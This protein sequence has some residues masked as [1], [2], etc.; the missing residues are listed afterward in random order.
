MK[1]R[2][3]ITAQGIA[4]AYLERDQCQCRVWVI[5]ENSPDEVYQEIERIRRLLN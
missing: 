1:A 2:R 5:K 3:I 4:Y